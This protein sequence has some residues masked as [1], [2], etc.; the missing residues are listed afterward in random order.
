MFRFAVCFLL[1]LFLSGVCGFGFEGKFVGVPEGAIE[2]QSRNLKS[3]IFNGLNYQS[4]IS[5]SLIKI[6]SSDE[7]K[8]QKY[9]VKE[10]FT[11]EVDDISEGEYQLL[12]NSYDFNIRNARFRVIK[13]Q[14][15]IRAFEDYLATDSFN[16]TSAQILGEGKPLVLQFTDY[17]QYYQGAQSKLSEMIMNS[18]LGMIFQSKLYTILAGMTVAMM[19][20]PPLISYFAPELAEKFDDL[21]QEA[22]Q[23][24]ATREAMESQAKAPREFIQSNKGPNTSGSS[25]RRK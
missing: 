1:L 3:P 5:V 7:L 17:K 14:S 20:G 25:R 6:D 4:R 2:S 12:V 23:M 10:D 11:F 16:S 18:P 9:P 15:Q 22:Y 24:K 19:I 21:Q 8:L 13:N